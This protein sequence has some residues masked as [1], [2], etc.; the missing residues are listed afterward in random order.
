MRRGLC[1]T[2]R[3]EHEAA[4]P[5][6]HQRAARTPASRAGACA[7]GARSASPSPRAAPPRSACRRASRRRG[8]RARPRGRRALRRDPSPTPSSPQDRGGRRRRSR[9]SAR[10]RRRAR[11][12]S[13][14]RGRRRTRVAPPSASR[15]TTVGPRFPAPPA[16]AMTRPSSAAP[17][18]HASNASWCAVASAHGG[19][20]VRRAPGAVP[21]HLADG[22]AALHRRRRADGRRRPLDQ[23]RRPRSADPGLPCVR[24]A[25]PLP[26][27]EPAPGAEVARD[28]RDLPADPPACRR[29]LLLAR[30]RARHARGA[31][32]FRDGVARRRAQRAALEQAARSPGCARARS[33]ASSA[34]PRSR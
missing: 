4:V 5:A 15:R 20:D 18:R 32:P 30:S 33:G 28:L 27:P 16:T 2:G 25:L 6:R 11:R 34:S 19:A 12:G 23:L 24:G 3:H 9:S 14:D 17:R 8:G 21:E 10:S 13:P 1:L 29:L 26:R 31:K 22:D 7:R